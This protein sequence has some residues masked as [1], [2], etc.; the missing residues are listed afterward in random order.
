[1]HHR[2][3]RP[4]RLRLIGL[5]MAAIPLFLAPAAAG[6][7]QDERLAAFKLF[8]HCEPFDLR[9][10]GLHPAADAIGLSRESILA[11]TESRLRTAGLLAPGSGTYLFINVNLGDE[12]FDIIMAFKK[13]LYDEYSGE[14][15]PATTWATGSTGTHEGRAAPILSSISGFM[16][17]FLDNFQQVNEA[18][19]AAR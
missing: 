10:G 18:A 7:E 2:V 15:H 4:N 13:P 16:D 8:T 1:M 3:Q 6:D 5:L 17:E 14:R 9:V 12:A 19:C 11:A